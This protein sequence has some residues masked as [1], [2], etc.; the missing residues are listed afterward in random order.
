MTK[1][2]NVFKDKKFLKSLWILALPVTVQSFI[3]SSL[4]LIDNVMV[5]SLGEQAI[6]SVGLA[7]Q[8]IFIFLLC[9]MG[10]NAGA[11]VFMSQ[12]WGKKDIQN[13]KK[14]LGLDIS[15]GLIASVLFTIACFFFPK[16]IMAIL[17]KDSIVINSGAQYLRIVAISCLFTNFTQAFSAALRSTGQVK[18]PMH[19]SI[20]GVLSNAVL[21]WIFIFGNLGMPAMGISGAALATMIARL[22][23]MI[24]IIAYVHLSQNIIASSL[25]EMFCFNKAFVKTYM[26]TSWPVILNELIYSVG[27]AA[28][29]VAYAR[30]GTNAVATMQI[31]NTLN[32]MFV[33]L[34]VGMATATSIMIGNKIGSGEEDTAREYA[35][36]TGILTPLVSLIMAACIWLLAPLILRAFNISASTYQDTLGVLRLMAIFFPMK[37]FNMVM[38]V[39]VFRGGGDTTYSMVVQ[40]G[41]IWLY[42]V[43]LAFIGATVFHLPVQMVFLLVSTEECVK[44]IF[45]ILRLKSGLWLKNV[46]EGVA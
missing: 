12:Y 36:H 24:Y 9:I 46:I 34:L 45:E 11:G 22:I 29:S 35:S 17:S 2:L 42:S 26:K 40:A 20:I 3:T 23:E 5:G 38:I 41:T 1:I 28:Y 14:V 30:I 32:N 43:P 37:A 21:N 33:V 13:I 31:A 19:A 15:V 44:I 8:F 7:N 27:L 6:A 39:G 18:V 16:N 4:N 25:K 10:I